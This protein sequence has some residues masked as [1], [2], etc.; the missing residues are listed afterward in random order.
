MDT[1]L[2]VLTVCK[3][4]YQTT[5]KWIYKNL[6]LT[7]PNR[8]SDFAEKDLQIKCFLEFLFM[9]NMFYP[10]KIFSDN[11][12]HDLKKIVK[13]VTQGTNFNNYFLFDKTLSSVSS[14]IVKFENN[15]GGN[16]LNQ[17]KLDQLIN[18]K[19]DIIAERVP[20]RQLDTKYSLESSGIKSNYPS[21]KTLYKRTALS[22]KSN[23]FYMS[24]DLSYS[25]THTIFYL[26]NMGRRNPSFLKNDQVKPLLLMLVSYYSIIKNYDILGEL[27]LCIHFLRINLNKQEQLLI[28][29]AFELIQ[30]G[31]ANDGIV[32]PPE[33]KV[34]KDSESEFFTCY[35]TTMVIMGA[36]YTYAK[37]IL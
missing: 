4:L 36:S 30:E 1:K 18:N 25:F 10:D 16:Y 13:R 26:T 7:D 6:D 28:G 27:L 20:Y 12:I 34:Q 15:F 37:Q 19:F 5:S 33:Y 2:K 21:L 17:T 29:D 3:N 11:H 14:E 35:H 24:D 32:P 31:Q 9:N 23:V 8:H 22:K